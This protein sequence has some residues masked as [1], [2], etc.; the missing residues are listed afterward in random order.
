[1]PRGRS[2]GW[3]REVLQGDQAG[4]YSARRGLP[5][6]RIH[7]LSERSGGAAGAGCTAHGPEAAAHEGCISKCKYSVLRQGCSGSRQGIQTIT[8]GG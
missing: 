7:G 5:S 2:S 6:W 4:L 3:L 1:M 8:G